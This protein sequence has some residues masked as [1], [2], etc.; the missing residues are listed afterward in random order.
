MRTDRSVPDVWCSR[1]AEDDAVLFDGSSM[2]DVANV[3]RGW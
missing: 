1:C 3:V 2:R